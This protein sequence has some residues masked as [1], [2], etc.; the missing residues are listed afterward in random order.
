MV[1]FQH[2]FSIKYS[3]LRADR[4]LMS[5]NDQTQRWSWMQY[6]SGKHLLSN[7]QFQKECVRKKSLNASL[8]TSNESEINEA[9]LILCSKSKQ[10]YSKCRKGSCCCVFRSAMLCIYH[11]SF[12]V[13]KKN[14][15]QPSKNGMREFIS[16]Y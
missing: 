12:P 2:G 13:G 9:E 14:Q 6:S 4:R 1:K 8:K 7:G 3:D 5:W 15:L 16:I 10:D 11:K